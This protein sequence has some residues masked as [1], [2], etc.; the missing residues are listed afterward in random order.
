M[1]APRLLSHL[2]ESWHG[3]CSCWSAGD[4]AFQ[5]DAVIT[6]FTLG[7]A[8]TTHMQ[9]SIPHANLES[10]HDLSMNGTFHDVARRLVVI[11]MA[12]SG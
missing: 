6:G 3:P 7:N 5:T 10:T 8:S 2:R 12:S 4:P 9:Q 11:Y 1:G